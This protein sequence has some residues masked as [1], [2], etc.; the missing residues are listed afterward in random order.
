MIKGQLNVSR[1]R[2]WEEA[3]TPAPSP[4]SRQAL[5][6]GVGGGASPRTAWPWAR[7]LFAPGRGGRG[8]AGRLLGLYVSRWA[9]GPAG[10]G[11]SFRTVSIFWPLDQ[12][13]RPSGPSPSGARRPR[14]PAAEA[15][16][17]L[18]GVGGL[19]GL[20]QWAWGLPTEG[21]DSEWCHG[22]G[23]GWPGQGPRPSAPP[24]LGQTA[25][26]PRRLR[27]GWSRPPR[28]AGRPRSATG[29]AEPE[30]ERLPSACAARWRSR[31]HALSPKGLGP[32]PLACPTWRR[33]CALGQP[34]GSPRRPAREGPGQC[35]R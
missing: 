5:G 16:L 30:S 24:G 34:R 6:Q 32:P 27:H 11:D 21:G 12:R 20:E 28:S 35:L 9:S 19:V 17:G 18:L 2:R 22:G 15:G 1:G 10:F 14:G 31:V 25:R 33:P 13:P 7:R 8:R 3:E 23:E 26:F 29:V 4:G